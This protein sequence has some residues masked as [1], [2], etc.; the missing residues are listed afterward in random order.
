MY[1]ATSDLRVFQ[2]VVV[3]KDVAVPPDTKLPV[4]AFTMV[5]LVVVGTEAIAT[6][7]RLYALGVMPVIVT[8]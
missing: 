5:K 2:D 7:D 6:P 1:F 4:A 8:F 3:V